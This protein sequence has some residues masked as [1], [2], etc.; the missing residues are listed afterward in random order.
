MEG[1]KVAAKF[2]MQRCGDKVQDG[3]NTKS[4][5]NKTDMIDYYT[6]MF[7]IQCKQLHVALTF[8]TFSVFPHCFFHTGFTN[9]IYNSEIAVFMEH[10]KAAS[11]PLVSSAKVHL[12]PGVWTSLAKP[13]NTNM[14][15]HTGPFGFREHI[16]CCLHAAVFLLHIKTCSSKTCQAKQGFKN[17]CGVQS[18]N[19]VRPI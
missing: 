10:L 2:E 11:F 19:N 17:A 15:V 16:V 18:C 3:I 7:A 14:A 12:L 9:H 4:T 5:Q 8:C 1:L 13:M 6:D